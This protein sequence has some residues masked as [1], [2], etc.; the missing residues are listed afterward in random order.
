MELNVYNRTRIKGLAG[1]RRIF[2]KIFEKAAK[3]LALNPQSSVSVIFVKDERMH[4]INR[5]YRG[6]DRTTDVIS[7]ALADN[8]DE[9]DYIETELGDI[10]INI[11][12]AVRQA[13]EYEHSEKR[14]ICFLF[15]HGLLHLCGFDHMKPEDEKVMIAKQKEILDDIVSPQDR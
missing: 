13:E 8:Q 5:D 9:N 15:T 7:F 14:E 12:A 2:E 10:F 11:D 3:N 1:Y 4:Q 6:I